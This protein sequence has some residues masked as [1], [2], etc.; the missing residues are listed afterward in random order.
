MALSDGSSSIANL[1]FSSRTAASSSWRPESTWASPV[2][3]TSTARRRGSWVRKPS[4]PVTLAR[5]AA[6][7]TS[8]LKTLSKLVL[9]APLRP[10]RPTLS[11]ARKPKVARDKTVRPPTSTLSSRASSTHP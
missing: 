1:S 10:T 11:P 5:P 7:A 8:P 2:A 4:P 3:S 6:G 9:P